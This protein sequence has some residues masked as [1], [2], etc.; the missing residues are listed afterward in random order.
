MPAYPHQFEKNQNSFTNKSHAVSEIF[1]AYCFVQIAFL[2]I[3]AYKHQFKLGDPVVYSAFIE[4]FILDFTFLMAGVSFSSKIF[5]K[6]F[7]PLLFLISYFL[8]MITNCAVYYFG[9]T[10][11]ELHHFSLITSYSIGGFLSFSSLSALPLTLLFFMILSHSCKKM[12]GRVR[13]KSILA[14]STLTVILL[15]AGVSTRVQAS[16]SSDKRLDKVI[17]VFRNAQVEY[18]SQNPLLYFVNNILLKAVSEKIS[19]Q[20]GR[21]SKT[22]FLKDYDFRSD[23]FAVSSD[24][25]PH[26]A[27]IER[28]SLPLGEKKYGNLKLNKFNRVIYIL[29]ESI[30]LE[31]LHCYNNKLSVPTAPNFFC[32][33]EVKKNTFTNLKT[34]ASPTL[35]GMNVIFSSH[36]NYQ[37]QK[38]TGDKNT[39]LSLLKKEGFKTMYMRS[40]SKFFANE[41]IIFDKW[42]F[43]VGIAREDFYERKELRKYIYG[44][45]LED[46]IL[47]NNLVTYLKDHREEK[48]FI[49]LLGTDTHPPYG[50]VAYR[51]LKY[52]ALP[53]KF[54]KTY[55]KSAGK[56]LK[57]VYNMDWDLKLLFDKLKKENLFTENTLIV[58]SA[59]HSSP[60]NNVTRKIP[61]HTRTNLGKIPFIILT[62]A[63]L[64]EMKRE[65]PSSQL[66]IAPTLSHMLGIQA[67]KGWWGESLFSHSKNNPPIGFN[68]GYIKIDHPENP[69]YFNSEKPKTATQKEF[70]KLFSTVIT[71]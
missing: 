14:W 27:S 54:Y 41:N 28:Y 9:N 39:L 46:R 18:A 19:I 11:I 35:Q 61:G 69:E 8:L 10:L 55:G 68:K 47:Y 70:Y 45:G 26:L 48:V 7:I 71:K 50:Q 20:T 56:W 67:P 62:P 42:G 3:V 34:T 65:T 24:L 6:H 51:H 33:D 4:K 60:A 25:T 16:K 64:P 66:D 43:D 63:K 29:L 23:D 52:P 30:S 58:L 21:A 53:K 15:V 2:S 12:T 1:L 57:S 5:K 22:K 37:I 59:D 49:T 40:A 36:P 31:T 32:T 44:W 17:T 38:I 13:W